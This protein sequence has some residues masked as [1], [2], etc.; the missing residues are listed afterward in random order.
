MTLEFLLHFGQLNLPSLSLK[1]RDKV[2][3]KCGLISTKTVEIFEYGKKNDRYW[4]GA[5]LHHQVM[6]KGLH[7][8]E[9]F[10]PR[11]FFFFFVTTQL[12]ILFTQIIRFRL[13]T[14]IRV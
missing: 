5:K 8:T 12:V 10:Y 13:R 9:A 11:Y 3:E 2:V 7:I 14:Q 4:D 6:K 1:K